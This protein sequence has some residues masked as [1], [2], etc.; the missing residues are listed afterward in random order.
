MRDRIVFDCEIQKTIEE[1]PGGWD[2]THLLGVSV[3]CLWEM[4][5]RRMRVYGP[6]DL[7]ALQNRLLQADEIIGYNIAKFDLPL[8]WGVSKQEWEGPVT[9][10]LR[11][12]LKPKTNDLLVRIWA[13]LGL[14]TSTFSDAHKGWGL[15]VVAQGTLGVGK[16][17]NG[18]DAPRWWQA[19]RWAKVVDYCSDDVA[20]ERDLAIFIDR[21]RFIVN[22][23][24][25]Q[26]VR[27]A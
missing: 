21:Y 9:A 12:T 6:D 14:N 3:C 23:K 24:T 19:G 4:Q 7:K 11:Q 27:I 2:S 16:I 8:V 10:S 22:G 1:T 26:V 5:T 13:G 25:Q 15:D 18:A 20:L 17:G